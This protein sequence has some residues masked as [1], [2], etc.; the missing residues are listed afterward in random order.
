V[1]YLKIKNRLILVHLFSDYIDNKD[2][3]WAKSKT[4]EIVGLLLKVNN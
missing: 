3:L 1:S 2:I 4:K